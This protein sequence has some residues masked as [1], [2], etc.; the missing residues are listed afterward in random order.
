MD[1]PARLI[2]SLKFQG[3]YER[4]DTN[5]HNCFVYFRF[6]ARDKSRLTYAHHFS[7][8]YGQRAS[9]RLP[10]HDGETHETEFA[11]KSVI[12]L[13]REQFNYFSSYF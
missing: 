12:M 6:D 4:E 11:K 13:Q 8:I 7:P 2:G 5:T 3:L 9:L 10:D 1:G